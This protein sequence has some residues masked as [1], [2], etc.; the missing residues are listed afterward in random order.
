LPIPRPR[1]PHI[2]FL[3]HLADLN[4]KL[5][6]IENV[7]GMIATG[8]RTIEERRAADRLSHEQSYR[9]AAALYIPKPQSKGRRTRLEKD[10]VRW[11]RWY[12]SDIFT[13]PFCD[14][15][16][17]MIHAIDRAV[18]FG[19]DQA[20]AAPRGEG[21]TTIAECVTLAKILPGVLTFAVIF[22]ATG[23]H[24]RNSLKSLKDYLIA[25]DRI[26]ADYPEVWYPANEADTSPQLAHSMAAQGDDF[27]LTKIKFQWSGDEITLPQVPGSRCAGS[28][29]ATRGLDAAVLGLKKGTLRPQLAIIDDPDTEDTIRNEEQRDK[30]EDRIDRAIAGLAP[31]GKRMSRVMLTTTRNR[32]CVSY[33]FTDPTIKPSWNGKRFGFVRKFPERVDLWEEYISLRGAGQ[34]AGD[35]FARNAHAFYLANLVE[36]DRAAE[37]ANPQS[38]DRKIVPDGS[39]LQVSALQRYY[40]WL[41]DNGPESTASELQNDPAEESGPQ[42]ISTITAHRVQRQVSGYPRK[43]VPPGCLKLTQGIDCKKSGLHWVVRAWGADGTGYTIDYGFHETHGTIVG[44]DVGL[45]TAL[46]RALHERREVIAEDPYTFEDGQVVDIAVTLVD[47]GW[48]DQAIYRFC[49]EA[50]A[51][52][53]PSKGFGQSAGCAQA[54]FHAPNRATL[55]KK[56]GDRWFLN[57]QPCGT[58]LVCMD[59]DFWKAWEHDRWVSDPAAPG[60]L[61]MWGMPSTSDRLSQDQKQHFSYSKHIVA[62]MEG[63][64]IIRGRL[65]RHWK[66]KSDT[67]HYL[68]ASYMA[69][70]GGSMVGAVVGSAKARRATA[71]WS[72]APSIGQIAARVKA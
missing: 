12:F 37:L 39:Q 71:D 1:K 46:I 59:A 65:V 22:A 19:G 2:L 60:A 31:R 45:D 11:L 8:K 69:D 14:H 43:I 4:V 27:P 52:F 13:E 35:T 28:I 53:K 57:R 34:T 72:N 54:G 36:M 56:M 16:L 10:T 47:S 21:K 40:D 70:V 32:I 61:F 9:K 29:I 6:Q 33:R 25:S 51:A 66:S 3:S 67:N 44:S 20:I 48:R 62:E 7:G 49:A 55:D 17:E 5:K 38:F 26:R 23:Y 41:A 42:D 15:H 68:D 50:G 30:L 63:E 18:T 24:A 64:D 58:W